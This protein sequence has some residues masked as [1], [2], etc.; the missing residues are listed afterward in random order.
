MNNPDPEAEPDFTLPEYTDARLIFTVEGKTDEEA[1]APLKE[2][3]HFNH[4]NCGRLGSAKADRAGGESCDS[5]ASSDFKFPV[6]EIYL[7]SLFHMPRIAAQNRSTS[8]LMRGDDDDLVPEVDLELELY[9]KAILAF[10]VAWQKQK[11][12]T[13][14]RFLKSAQAEL[15]DLVNRR[16]AAIE[17]SM[18]QMEDLYQDFLSRYAA[19]EDRKRKL[20]VQIIEKQRT[21]LELSVKK[22][23]EAVENVQILRDGQR[24]GIGLVKQAFQDMQGMVDAFMQD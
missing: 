10:K 22:H 6:D 16:T 24:E 7:E 1:A 21:L 3:W 20:L 8:R 4:D 19:S 13:E 9:A 15:E 11:E 17:G 12:E 5:T 14:N 18:D 2:V 23:Q